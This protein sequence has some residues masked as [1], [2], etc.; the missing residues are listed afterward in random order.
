M[1][2]EIGTTC[3]LLIVLAFLAA[4]DV[5][6]GYLSDVG[7]RRL[8]ADHE[9]RPTVATSFLTEILEDRPR[10]RFT[11]STAIQILLVAVSVL[12]TSITLRA[13]PNFT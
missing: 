7:L 3:L 12:V 5:A 11:L 8:V 1:E 4:I 13:F 6:F 9:D 10:F 2:I